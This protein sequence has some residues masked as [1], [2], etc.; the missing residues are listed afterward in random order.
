MKLKQAVR[1]ARKSGYAWVAV[2]ENK[3]IYMY[4]VKP[5]GRYMSECWD[6]AGPSSWVELV[7]KYTGS[8][9]WKDTLREVK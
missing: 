5:S 1:K 4:K 2:D 9:D 6:T 7:E 3:T 8:K